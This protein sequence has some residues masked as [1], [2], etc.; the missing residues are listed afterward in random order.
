LRPQARAATTPHT[1]WTI[2][3]TSAAC[4]PAAWAIWPLTHATELVQVGQTAIAGG[5][6][7]D[8]LAGAVFNVPTFAEAYRVAALDAASRLD[9]LA[10]EP[11]TAVACS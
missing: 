4:A 5:L 10:R 1:E 9:S 7:V 2:S 6:T 11:A 8:D 3:G